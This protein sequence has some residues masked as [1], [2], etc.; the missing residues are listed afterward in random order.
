[1]AGGLGP[2]GPGGGYGRAGGRP[3]RGGGPAGRGAPIY[4][5]DGTMSL[6]GRVG[7]VTGAAR[8][9]GLAIARRLSADGA[10]VALV[11]LDKSAVE[12]AAGQIGASTLALVADV[13]RTDDVER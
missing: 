5:G 4:E 6:S 12:A 1:R 9:I 2:G 7:L 13:T 3:W 10:S 8:G 11:D